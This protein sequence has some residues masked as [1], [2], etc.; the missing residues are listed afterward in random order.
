VRPRGLPSRR[1]VVLA[2]PADFKPFPIKADVPLRRSAP[3]ALRVNWLH[4]SRR[5]HRSFPARQVSMCSAPPTCRGPGRPSDRPLSRC[6]IAIS[7]SRR[8]RPSCHAERGEPG[9]WMTSASSRAHGDRSASRSG[10]GSRSSRMMD[11]PWSS[12]SRR[13][14]K[15]RS[16]RRPSVDGWSRGADRRSSPAGGPSSRRRRLPRPGDRG[17]RCARA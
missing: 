5:S 2:H 7:S 17:S 9:A 6:R 4:S 11:L 13:G 16:S 8:E 15:P 14:R 10:V 12:S 1:P 3:T